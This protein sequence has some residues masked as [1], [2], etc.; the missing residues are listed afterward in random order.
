VMILDVLKLFEAEELMSLGQI[1]QIS[2][3]E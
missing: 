2:E 1:T 3:G